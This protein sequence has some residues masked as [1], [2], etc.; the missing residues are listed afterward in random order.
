MK[1]QLYK[2]E[3]K[4]LK[5]LIIL[6]DDI[7]RAIHNAVIKDGQFAFDVDDDLCQD[8]ADSIAAEANHA[9]TRRHEKALDDLCDKILG[10]ID[11]FPL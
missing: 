9:D 1:I 8:L 6:D 11:V 10:Q 5:T 4:L 3:M 2:D 7:E